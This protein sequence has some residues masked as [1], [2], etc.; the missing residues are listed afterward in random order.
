MT[1]LASSCLAAGGAWYGYSMM[2]HQSPMS[3]TSGCMMARCENPTG[4]GSPEGSR[5]ESSNNVEMIND[6]FVPQSLHVP[7]GA[8]VT[9]WNEDAVSHTI[10][11]DNV[12]ASDNGT[13]LA[14]PLVPS[15]GSWTTTFPVA[16]TYRYHCTPHSYEDRPGAYEGMIGTILVGS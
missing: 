7:V 11:S 3:T 6:A 14:S 15:G 8:A 13:A 1:I 4:P 2:N 12:T 5:N 10:T 16:G 9:W